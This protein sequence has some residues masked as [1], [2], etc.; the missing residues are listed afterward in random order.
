MAHGVS[1]VSALRRARDVQ[2]VI[3]SSKYP[4]FRVAEDRYLMFF[5]SP[6]SSPYGRAAWGIV[7][8]LG[9]RYPFK[10]PSVSFFKPLH[11]PNVDLHTGAI[12]FEPLGSGWSAA[13]RLTQLLE[14]SLPFFTENPNPDDPLSGR[15]AAQMTRD[16]S[17]YALE[18]RACAAEHAL[19]RDEACDD[20]ATVEAA[21]TVYAEGLER[22]TGSE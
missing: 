9:P 1:R 3:A 16:P 21:L 15:V 18:C 14:V 8:E 5:E 17:G 7:F 11:H 22:M 20:A 2:Q 13:Q 6:A 12:C 19:V 10:S 4:V